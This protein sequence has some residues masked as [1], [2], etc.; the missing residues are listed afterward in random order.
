MYNVYT[1][2][3]GYFCKD[4]KIISIFPTKPSHMREMESLIN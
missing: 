4:V 3:T 1:I 2:Y